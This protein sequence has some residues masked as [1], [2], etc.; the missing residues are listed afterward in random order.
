MAAFAG[1]G[2]VWT[3][4]MFRQLFAIAGNTF[5]EAIR[6]PI[7]FVLTLAGC[8]LQTANLALSAYSMGFT[9][10]GKEVSG[11][12][13]L[14][15]DMGLA[16]VFVV[17][18]LLAA[19]VATNV[20]SRE[21][22]NKTALTVVSKPVG[23]PLFV[24]GKY[25]GAV[26]AI[27]LSLASM[28][29]F[30]FLAIR[31]EV[32]S[33]A[34]DSIDMPVLIFAL[35][36]I[37]IAVGV[38]VWGN[39]FYGWVFSSVATLLLAP[40]SLLSWVLSVIVGKEWEVLP[41]TDA[42]VEWRESHDGVGAMIADLGSM[43]PPTEWWKPEIA[44][45]A[46]CLVLAMWVLTAVAVAVST[47]AGQVLTLAIA[48]AVFMAGLLSNYAVGR[49][50][51]ENEAITRV[52]AVE[53][54]NEFDDFREP[55][56]RVTLELERN[57]DADLPTGR[58]V[59]LGVDPSGVDILNSGQSPRFTGDVDNATHVRT[60]SY[61]R[62]VVVVEHD[63]GDQ[64]LEIVNAG[65]APLEREPMEGDF[66]FLQETQINPVALAAWSVVPNLQFFWLIDAITQGHAIPWRYMGL[67]VL[68]SLAQIG[69]F[70]SV[71]VMLFQTRD[72]G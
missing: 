49:F 36:S 66:L 61:G 54:D 41:A 63:R 18:T 10:E 12:D 58:V 47:R 29:P 11:D 23:R 59:Y 60:P 45:A 9:E 3:N 8:L 71:A 44:L 64:T 57:P 1:V 42:F 27:T 67:A 35:S 21:I 39:F 31:H 20:I 22:E 26:G 62:A 7:F 37:G 19:F 5:L 40:L 24:L 72:L 43:P 55:G 2:G 52:A 30:F 32:M 48:A 38:A 33:T 13:K 65:G 68:Y 50:A 28:I 25:L 15:L 56:E 17:A 51:Y 69:A 70:L 6:Q 53:K 46:V 14:L 16:T 4:P 34:R